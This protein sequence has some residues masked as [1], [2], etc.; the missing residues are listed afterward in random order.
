MRCSTEQLSVGNGKKSSR[1]TTHRHTTLAHTLHST[2][3]EQYAMMSRLSQMRTASAGADTQH[4]AHTQSHK[5]RGLAHVVVV[6]ACRGVVVV[7]VS[8]ANIVAADFVSRQ[9][10]LTEVCGALCRRCP[11]HGAVIFF[12][13]RVVQLCINCVCVCPG[14]Q[15]SER[16]VCASHTH[17][18]KKRCSELP[19]SAGFR[20]TTSSNV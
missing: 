17:A 2:N 7:A 10:Q 1:Q 8:S 12:S 11:L 4:T 14:A 13:A 19:A 18:Q 16:C 5:Q 20:C 6:Y 3:S 9:M 15:H